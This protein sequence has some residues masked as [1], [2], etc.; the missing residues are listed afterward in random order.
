M[1]TL[2]TYERDPKRLQ[3]NFIGLVPV[4][5]KITGKST[6]SI[7][8]VLSLLRLPEEIQGTIKSRKIGK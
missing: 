8:R 4:L 5:K 2:M 3:E 6:S 1:N 7:K